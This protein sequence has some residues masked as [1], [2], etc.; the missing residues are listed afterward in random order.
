MEVN[1]LGLM[2]AAQTLMAAADEL[3]A[4]TPPELQALAP[5]PTSFGAAGRLDAASTAAWSSTCAQAMSLQTVASHLVMIAAR[6]G[7]QEELNKA[8]LASLSA[9][10]SGMD[11]G[12]LTTLSPIPPLS[13]D[14]RPPLPPVNPSGEAFSQLVTAGSSASAVDFSTGATTM[15]TTVQTV[16]LTLKQVAAS[17]PD[18]W[19]S[20]TGTA[21]L[22]G[23]INEH[24]NALNAIAD[25]WSELADRARQHGGQYD[26]AVAAVPKPQ[27]FKDNETALR[28]AQAA[29][30]PVAVSQLIQQRGVLEQRALTTAARYHGETEATT[31][32]PGAAAPPGTVAPA[33]S[34]GGAPGITGGAPAGPAPAQAQP[35]KA[36]A[37]PASPAGRAGDAAG[38]LAQLLPQ[39]L[40][41]IGGMAGGLAGMA[42]Q[43]PQGLMQTGQGLAQTATRGLS[44]LTST[45]GSGAEPQKV[46]GTA[47]PD[48]LAKKAGGGDGGGAAG[49]THPAGALGPPVILSTSHTPP[50]MPSGAAEPPAAPAPARGSTMGGMPMGMPI[51]GLTHGGQGGG[52]GAEKV[53]ADRKVVMPPQPHTEAVTGKVSDRTAAAA[54]AAR[55]RTDSSAHN[56]QPPRTV[57]RRITLA[58]L[59]EERS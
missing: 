54:E 49:D 32:V 37:S 27:E 58:P 17:V 52:G 1:V 41:A 47:T 4:L 30:N 5:D 10:V 50:T 56:E 43:L 48:E 18:L 55:R 12:A 45:T 11:A 39:A 40:G 6:F 19:E 46:V 51:G 15:S 38:Q 8:H 13:P 36:G 26:D 29:G 9:A 59:R 14:V 53:P 42:G 33:G 57:V 34:G 44:G 35:V 16:A 24:A 22:S 23:R 21:A 25:Q 28:N 3:A 2:L 7:T 31:A 20:P